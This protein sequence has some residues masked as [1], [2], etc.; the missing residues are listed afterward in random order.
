MNEEYHSPQRLGSIEHARFQGRQDVQDLKENDII[1]IKDRAISAEYDD[2]DE[3]SRSI[4]RLSYKVPITATEQ[5]GLAIS[6]RNTVAFRENYPSS[7]I[8]NRQETIRRLERGERPLLEQKEIV[9][10]TAQAYQRLPEVKERRKIEQKKEEAEHRRQFVR[11]MDA[12][13]R[14][15]LQ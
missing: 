4:R 10:R 12:R 1:I 5:N 13:R 8:T 2:E 11:E 3:A 6:T 14:G 7:A 15:K 9:R